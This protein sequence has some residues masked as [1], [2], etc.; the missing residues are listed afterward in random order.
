MRK[1]VAALG[2]IGL[3]LAVLPGAILSSVDQTSAAIGPC[4]P[5]GSANL[6]GQWPMNEGSGTTTADTSGNGNDTCSGEAMG[7]CENQVASVPE[8]SGMEL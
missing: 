5:V 6:V 8:C 2:S 7:S 3:A 4:T 1:F